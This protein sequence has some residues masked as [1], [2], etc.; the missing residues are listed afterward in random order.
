MNFAY[1]SIGNNGQIVPLLCIND[2]SS[3]ITKEKKNE[4]KTERIRIM[5]NNLKQEIRKAKRNHYESTHY[6]TQVVPTSNEL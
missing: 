1:G 4:W 3:G 5:E 2:T 6:A